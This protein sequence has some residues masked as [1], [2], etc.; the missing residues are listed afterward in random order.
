MGRR[1]D[2]SNRVKGPTWIPSKKRWRIVVIATKPS[3]GNRE[4]RTRWFDDAEL[5]EVAKEEIEA[6]FHRLSTI[7][8]KQAIEQYREH[9]KE[10][11]TVEVSYNETARRLHLFF[12]PSL[13]VSR[14]TPDRAKSYYEKFRKRARPDGKPISVA[15]HRAAL[16]NARSFLSWCVERGWLSLNPLAG[17]KGIGKR[18]SRKQQLTG[19]E[20]RKLWAH[21]LPLAKRG[22]RAALGVLAAWLMALRS[23]DLCRRLVRDVDL[24]ATQ[25]RIEDGKSEESNEPREIPEVLKPLFR[26]L[27]KGRP[28]FEPLFKTP[29]TASGHHTRRWLEEAMVRF[30]RAAGVPY[31]CPHALKGQ[32][33]TILAR[34]GVPGNE[35][36][37]YLSHTDEAIS[38]RHYIKPGAMAAAN[39]RA[40]LKVIAGGRR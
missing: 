19:D 18:R 34:K 6:G 29:Y 31:V 17:V 28:P 25:L 4:R 3:T 2:E 37:E 20:M 38:K 24:D 39:S 36:A 12:P 33:G 13:A 22:D 23:A 7:T 16:I 8:T 9:L 30:C 32:A 21:C 1:R 14:I 5:A 10:K 27:A 11:G 15:Y 35:I 26:K 40:A